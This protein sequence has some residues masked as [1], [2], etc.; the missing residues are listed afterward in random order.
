MEMVNNYSILCL[1]YDF[2]LITKLMTA[3]ENN[4]KHMEFR[5]EIGEDNYNLRFI[6][7]SL[8]EKIKERYYLQYIF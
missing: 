8:I 1:M 5:L 3:F 4:I 6:R 7:S 2:C